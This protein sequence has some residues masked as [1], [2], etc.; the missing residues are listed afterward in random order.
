MYHRIAD[1]IEEG[2]HVKAD[3][4]AWGHVVRKDGEIRGHH[5]FDDDR[6]REVPYL[7]H[8]KNGTYFSVDKRIREAQH[9]YDLSYGMPVR[10]KSIDHPSFPFPRKDRDYYKYPRAHY[11]PEPRLLKRKSHKYELAGQT[12]DKHYI[13]RKSP[14][15]SK[16]RG[17]FCHHNQSFIEAG[18]DILTESVQDGRK[19]KNIQLGVTD[20]SVNHLGQPPSQTKLLFLQEATEKVSCKG[21]SGWAR[22]MREWLTGMTGSRQ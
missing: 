8:F 15:V 21:P 17:D 9:E 1:A 5:Y 7:K 14:L 13:F 16:H 22:A 18:K 10:P 2:D 3:M 4:Y 20:C 11:P 19:V 6:L 12:G